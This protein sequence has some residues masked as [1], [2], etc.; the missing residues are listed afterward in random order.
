[1]NKRTEKKA[2]V[3]EDGPQG[4]GSLWLERSV[5]FLA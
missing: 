4:N 2:D 5:V 3:L 1:M